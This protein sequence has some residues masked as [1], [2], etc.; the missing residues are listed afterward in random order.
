MLPKPMQKDEI[1]FRNLSLVTAEAIKNLIVENRLKPGDGLESER[2]LAAELQVSRGTVREAL[3]RL[4][5]LDILE[6][7]PSGWFVKSFRAAPLAE[8]LVHYLSRR[9]ESMRDLLEA[10]FILETGAMKLAM[11]K[12]RDSDIARLEQ[13]L[14]VYEKKSLAG[15]AVTAEEIEFHTGI[16]RIIGNRVLN[17]FV[18]IIVEFLVVSDDYP[19]HQLRAGLTH[20]QSTELTHAGHRELLEILRVKDPSRVDDAVRN[21]LFWL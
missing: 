7:R 15:E 1:D 20:E 17:Q 18:H 13:V 11:S 16:I 5:T 4:E 21:H 2:R 19:D 9:K 8:Q 14:E 3:K 6:A 10:R 12:I